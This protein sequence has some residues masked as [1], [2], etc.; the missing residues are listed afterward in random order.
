MCCSSCEETEKPLVSDGYCF[1]DLDNNGI[2]KECY[3]KLTKENLT[4]KFRVK[5]LDKSRTQ[6]IDI[7]E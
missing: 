1:L 3:D 4:K 6:D 2:C 7:Y 5:W